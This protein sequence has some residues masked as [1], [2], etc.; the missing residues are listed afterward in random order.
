MRSSIAKPCADQ[1]VNIC[2]AEGCFAEACIKENSM[3]FI[4]IWFPGYPM[5]LKE[6]IERTKDLWAMCMADWLPKRVTYWI[7][8]RQIGKATMTSQ[9]VPATSLDNILTNLGNLKDGKPLVQF[10]W[11]KPQDWKKARI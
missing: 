10:K 5:A 4:S 3:K 1:N 8:M 9:N 7:A 6:K 11:K 2:V